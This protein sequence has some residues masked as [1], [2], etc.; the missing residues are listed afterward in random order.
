[1]PR[2]ICPDLVV[3]GDFLKGREAG[4]DVVNFRRRCR[5]RGARDAEEGGD[6]AQGRCAGLIYTNMLWKS[7]AR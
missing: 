4:E 5:E 3:L 6:V 1:M 2:L 7:G